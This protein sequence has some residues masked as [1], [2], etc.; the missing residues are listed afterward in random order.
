MSD[1][2]ER[3]KAALEGVTEGGWLHSEDNCGCY[4]IDAKPDLTVQLIAEC[5]AS[6]ADA[7]FLAASRTLVPE[8]V[9]EVERLHA[10]N[11][12][13]HELIRR[14]LAYGQHFRT[15]YAAAAR[16]ELRRMAGMNHD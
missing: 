10:E 14:G 16:A 2:V 1:I 13:L 5:I 15:A 4:S 11:E 12:Q 6:E 9:A 7:E 3:A 8:L